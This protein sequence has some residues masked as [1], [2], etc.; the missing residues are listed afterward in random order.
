MTRTIYSY[1]NEAAYNPYEFIHDAFGS[2]NT[3]FQLKGGNDRKGIFVP[4]IQLAAEDGD[5]WICKCITKDFEIKDQNFL[6]RTGEKYYLS[7]SCPQNIKVSTCGYCKE[8]IATRENINAV[9]MMQIHL[10][11]APV[12]GKNFAEEE[13]DTLN[14]LKNEVFIP[15][16]IPVPTYILLNGQVALIYI[17]ENG[18]TLPTKANEKNRVLEQIE[19]KAKAICAAINSVEKSCRA[20]FHTINDSVFVP[21]IRRRQMECIGKDRYDNCTFRTIFDRYVRAHKV[22]S[23]YTIQ[24]FL[25]TELKNEISRVTLSNGSE[26]T[27]FLQILMHDKR[28]AYVA[29]GKFNGEMSFDY[30]KDVTEIKVPGDDEKNNYYVGLHPLKSQQNVGEN[31]FNFN[32]LFIDLDAH[33]CQGNEMKKSINQTRIIF[34]EAFEEGGLPK[35]TMML[36]T[37]GGLALYYVFE[38]SIPAVIKPAREKYFGLWQYLN[39]YI[40]DYLRT[41]GSSMRADR[42]VINAARLCRLPGTVNPKYDS[43]PTCRLLWVNKTEHGEVCYCSMDKLSDDS[44]YTD[45]V[46]TKIEKAIEKQEL[47]QKQLQ[48]KNDEEKNT[49]TSTRAHSGGGNR[50][51][52]RNLQ[53]RRIYH[54]VNYL[55]KM[56]YHCKGQRELILFYL[57]N[58]LVYLMD[59]ERAMEVVL[60]V[61]N[62][63]DEP[64]REKEVRSCMKSVPRYFREHGEG[65]RVTNDKIEFDLGIDSELREKVGMAKTLRELV[66][67]ENSYLLQYQREYEKWRVLDEAIRNPDMKVGEIAELYSRSKSWVEKTLKDAGVRKNKKNGKKTIM[68]MLAPFTMKK[69]RII[70]SQLLTD[71]M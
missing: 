15:A 40:Q 2:T 11:Y 24:S 54:I 48:Q 67:D 14:Q 43:K 39:D 16:K 17:F 9:A 68:P 28:D 42:S 13:I 5:E 12:R 32:A 70:V 59:F 21:G 71:I 33:D 22:G 18:T 29:T 7:E 26:T 4:G 62:E 44:G 41:H 66:S 58:C 35:P 51:N 38:R 65:Y 27:R 55:E 20:K 47:R 19:G 64:L 52:T 49:T 8:G 6:K 63:F 46:R 36:N 56:D 45:Y 60:R 37:G 53:I 61:N 57:C 10:D 31:V 1:Q 25:G 30:F 50:N 3:F 34:T 23:K 69:R